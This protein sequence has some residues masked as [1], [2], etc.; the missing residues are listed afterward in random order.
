MLLHQ[1]ALSSLDNGRIGA[2]ER[3]RVLLDLVTEEQGSPTNRHKE[4]H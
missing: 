1:K 4:V 2:H 3:H